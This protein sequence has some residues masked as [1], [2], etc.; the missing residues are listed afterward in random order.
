MEQQQL[1]KLQQV[2]VA[3]AEAEAEQGLAAVEVLELVVLAA[4]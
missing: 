1:L 3:Q 2:M 4:Y